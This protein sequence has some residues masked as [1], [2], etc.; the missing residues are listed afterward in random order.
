MNIFL[1]AEELFKKMEEMLID[2]NNKAHQ[3]SLCN[4]KISDVESKFLERYELLKNELNELKNNIN[5]I[6]ENCYKYRDENKEKYII[7]KED[8]NRKIAD[9]EKT[10]I[11]K[12]SV[13]ST[14]NKY[15]KEI[16]FIILGM[17]VSICTTLITTLLL[18][19]V[20][21]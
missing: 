5:E 18:K 8:I 2:L 19:S 17:I 15:I 16:V 11:E 6:K 10:L 9:I 14:S 20:S 13:Q 21:I 1:N 4:N 7:A 12:T 3:I